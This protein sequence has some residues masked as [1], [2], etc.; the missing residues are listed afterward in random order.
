MPPGAIGSVVLAPST[1][2]YTYTP[3]AGFSGTDT[4]TYR[5][6]LPAP[7]AALCDDATVQISVVAQ[8]PPVA[9]S[10]SVAGV[11]T[12]GQPATGNY[13]YTDANADVQGASTFRW[14]RSPSNSVAAGTN[15]ATTMGY[16]PVA[17]DVG[18]FLFFCVTPVAATGATP[19]LEVCSPASQIGFA[20][21]IPTLSQWGMII[22]SILMGCFTT[23]FARRRR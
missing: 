6:C 4:S 16:T 21:P 12:I 23:A 17:G 1:G 8:V 2:A 3:N 22:L 13:T 11:P 9:L 15:V 14:V 7:N 10:V 18:N 20:S 5:V 19:G